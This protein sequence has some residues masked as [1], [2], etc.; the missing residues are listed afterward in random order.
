VSELAMAKN[1]DESD[2]EDILSKALG[3]AKLKF[4]E[5][6]DLNEN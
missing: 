5:I 1:S 3:K 6:V 4:P 2:I